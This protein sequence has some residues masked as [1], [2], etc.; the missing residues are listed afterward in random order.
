MSRNVTAALK[1]DHDEILADLAR[2]TIR[3]GELSE[4]A[5]KIRGLCSAHFELEEK[6]VFTLF[7]VANDVTH[8]KMLRP[9]GEI[10]D[11]VGEFD[12]YLSSLRLQHR[13]LGAALERFSFMAHRQGT[14][15]PL[16]LARRLRDHERMEHHVVYP[17]AMLVRSYLSR[18][19]C[20][21][22]E[23]VSGEE[24]SGKR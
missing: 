4:L 21:E 24:V 9:G 3:S 15:E 7:S 1:Q 10:L 20:R 8:G 2:A 14:E 18:Q 19:H 22:R 6:C 16:G 11:Q 17:A 5:L 13:L 23:T 12:A